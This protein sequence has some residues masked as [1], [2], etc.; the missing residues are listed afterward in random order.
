MTSDPS[1]SNLGN[2]RIIWKVQAVMDGLPQ[3]HHWTGLKMGCVSVYFKSPSHPAPGKEDRGDCTEE[4]IFTAWK[5]LKTLDI[6]LS[7]PC[8]L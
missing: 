4:L 3:P 2:I 6:L 7:L 5:K 8:I 1:E